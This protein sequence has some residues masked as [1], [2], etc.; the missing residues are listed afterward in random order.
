M[1]KTMKKKPTDK[2]RLFQ[3]VAL[4]QVKFKCCMWVEH[5]KELNFSLLAK[6]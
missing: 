3:C 1:K 4:D 6:L 5:S 2:T